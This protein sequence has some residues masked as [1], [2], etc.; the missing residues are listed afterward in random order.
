[1][2]HVLNMSMNLA[3]T[4]ELIKINEFIVDEKRLPPQTK[5]IQED[6]T[7]YHACVLTGNH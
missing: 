4:H 5:D 2:G 1:M 6:R 3:E 7:V